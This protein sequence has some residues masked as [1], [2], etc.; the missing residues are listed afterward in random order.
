MVGNKGEED[1]P[2]KSTKSTKEYKDIKIDTDRINRMRFRLRV[3]VH[4]SKI[5][6]VGFCAFCAF[7]A[8]IL[9]L[10]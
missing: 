3:A 4:R 8:A 5:I 9:F 6:L 2:Q 7:F 10:S 1:W